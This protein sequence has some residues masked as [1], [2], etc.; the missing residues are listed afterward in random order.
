MNEHK[1]LNQ[2]TFGCIY[3]PEIPC[4]TENKRKS[5]YQPNYI[6]K[7]QIESEGKIEKEIGKLIVQIPSYRMHFAPVESICDVEI[8]KIEEDEIKKCK[9]LQEGKERFT[10][11]RIR[12]VGKQVLGEFLK[13]Y[14]KNDS[15]FLKKVIETHLYILSSLSVLYDNN[16]IHYDLKSNNIIM[17]DK[18]GIPVLID[19]GLSFQLNSITDTFKEFYVFYDKHPY[20]SL[21]IMLLSYLSEKLHEEASNTVNDTFFPSSSNA[22]TGIDQEEILN[23]IESYIAK[24]EIFEPMFFTEEEKQTFLSASI[25]YFKEMFETN[26][27]W[28]KQDFMRH[29]VETSS[30]SWDAFSI[31]VMYMFFL[32]SAKKLLTQ[33][34]TNQQT[35]Q[36]RMYEKYNMFLKKIIMSFPNRLS[37]K[38]CYQ[39]LESMILDP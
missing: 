18:F 38:Q 5:K 30:N 2:G 19:F 34:D 26:P 14:R 8:G 16:I 13:S 3:T 31:A 37:S 11:N 25:H 15:I 20:W 17:D 28:T 12:Y 23:V 35:A 9:V 10:S 6:S 24:N 22:N 7:I 27:L 33:I 36:Y 21:E 39:E 4:G 32:E 29:L 1:F